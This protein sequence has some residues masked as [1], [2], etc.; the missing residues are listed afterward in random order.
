MLGCVRHQDLV[1][2]VGGDEFLLLL[3]T[4][5]GSEVA[6]EAMRLIRKSMLSSISIGGQRLLVGTS[7]GFAC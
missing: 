4:P 7:I 3:I 2:R 6:Q 5:S 1:T